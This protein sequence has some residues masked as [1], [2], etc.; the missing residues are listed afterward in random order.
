MACMRWAVYLYYISSSTLCLRLRYHN[1]WYSVRGCGAGSH[2][3]WFIQSSQD[4]QSGTGC[5]IHYS[6]AD[7]LYACSDEP[8]QLTNLLLERRD[9]MERAVTRRIVNFGA[10][11]EEA[12]GAH[13]SVGLRVGRPETARITTDPDDGNTWRK[14]TWMR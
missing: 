13:V 7:N 6:Q 9:G 10:D 4:G 5:V 11:H 1:K 12:G 14:A 2:L 8:S 3:R